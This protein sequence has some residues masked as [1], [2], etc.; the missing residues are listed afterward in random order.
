M[1]KHYPTAMRK[2]FMLY[3]LFL[4]L[5]LWAISQKC[6]EDFL[7]G[8]FRSQIKE[9]TI[10]GV[11]FSMYSADTLEL[12]RQW[13]YSH[14]ESDRRADDQTG[15]MVGSVSKL[16]L[17]V[18]VMQLV[19]QGKLDIH[20]PVNQYLKGFTLPQAYQPVTMKHLMTHTPGFEDHMHLFAKSM[21]V[22]PNIETYLEENLPAQIFEPG[23]IPAYSNYGTVLAAYVVEQITGQSFYD[24]TEQHIFEPLGMQQTTFRQPGSFSIA[25]A[26]S[27]G[28]LFREGRFTSPFEEFVIP[29]PAGSAVSTAP[30]M[31]RFMRF[32]LMCEEGQ[33][34]ATDTLHVLNNETIAQMLS[35]LHKPHP[36]SAGMAYGF[37]RMEYDEMEIFWHGGNTMLFHTAFVLVPEMQTGIFFSI[38]TGETGF[39][40]TNQFLLI[41]DYLNRKTPKLNNYKR[42]NGLNGYAGT[43]K[44]TRRTEKNY[45][46]LLSAVMT[47]S[48][49]PVAEGLL[50]SMQGMEPELF[51]PYEEDVFVS[52]HRKL[53]FER[54]QRG[55][56][57]VLHISDWPIMAF[58]KV[59]FRE[60][61]GFNL[62]LLL[63]AIFICLRNIFSP[64]FR[65]FKNDKRNKQTFRWLLF[66]SGIFLM[67]FFITFASAFSSIESILFEKP[68]GLRLILLL[69]LTSLLFFVAGVLFW[70]QQNIWSRQPIV[71]TLWQFT[72][73]LIMVW[74]YLQMHFWKLF[75]FMV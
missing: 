48:V 34:D 5:P 18:A 22:L 23:S 28:Y 44:S 55:R 19:E 45:L 39:N 71:R 2:S 75:N 8:I 21:E 58:E 47:V 1:E 72:G 74:F 31:L 41:L 16:F 64:L 62:T 70:F 66:F 13:G 24:Y 17:W 14:V 54:N 56:I 43:Y 50:A 10:A 35:I 57:S 38:N 37:M 67:I 29:Y 4:L 6:T 42:V 49:T 51:R 63:L 46:K 3:A 36:A 73:L 25:E 33:P 32:M 30:D 7:E 15:F 61:I 11:T 69:P 26:K 12:T 53:I 27:N 52:G 68:S 40:Y 9:H 60:K 20:Q 65:F 59:S